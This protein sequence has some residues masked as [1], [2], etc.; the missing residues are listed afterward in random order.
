M[1]ITASLSS[2]RDICF[3]QEAPVPT[4]A[5]K[6]LSMHD[7]LIKVAELLPHTDLPSF[8][9]VNRSFRLASTEAALTL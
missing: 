6:A 9:L 3:L 7:L 1:F 8:R 5:Q 2:Q 4:A